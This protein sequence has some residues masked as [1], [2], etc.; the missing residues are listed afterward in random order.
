MGSFSVF[1]EKDKVKETFSFDVPI[2]VQMSKAVSSPIR[3]IPI[4]FFCYRFDTEI[5]NQYHRLNTHL[6]KCDRR[7]TL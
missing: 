4:L 3:R 2:F 1:G 7:H 5:Y 6:E